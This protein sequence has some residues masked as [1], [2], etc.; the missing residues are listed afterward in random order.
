MVVES[1]VKEGKTLASNLAVLKDRITLREGGK[2]IY[3]SQGLDR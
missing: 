2:Q 1:A 3:G